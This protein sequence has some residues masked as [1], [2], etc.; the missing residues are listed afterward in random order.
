MPSIKEMIINMLL[1][2]LLAK[3][4]YSNIA[5]QIF[6]QNFQSDIITPSIHLIVFIL[7]IL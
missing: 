4:L 5:T 1:V 2:A 3:E 6:N 7:M